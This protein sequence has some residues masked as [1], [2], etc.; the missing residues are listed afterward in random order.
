MERSPRPNLKGLL[1]LTLVFALITTAGF[2]SYL[3][4]VYSQ[5]KPTGPAGVGLYRLTLIEAMNSEWNS[6]LSQ[7][8]FYV[9]SSNG[10]ESSANITVPAKTLIQLTIISYDTPTPGNTDDMGVVNGTVGRNV[11]LINGTTASMGAMP[12]VWGQNVTSVP[13]A[14]LAHTITISQLGINIPVVGGDTEI[15][16]LYFPKPGTYT[17]ICETP[18]GFGPDGSE[19]AMS[20]AGWM[21]GQ[22]VVS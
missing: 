1:T 9:L 7:P 20:T 22:F 10:F 8:R 15:A 18:C 13:G 19:G 3:A 14:M 2:G 4:T 21:T 5:P 12:Q 17:W 11:F 16:Y 6:T